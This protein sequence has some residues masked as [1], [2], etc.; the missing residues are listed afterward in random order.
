MKS[1][2]CLLLTI[3][4]MLINHS[5]Q[6]NEKH[7]S[8][9]EDIQMK[10]LQ[11]LPSD[12]DSIMAE[13]GDDEAMKDLIT[14]LGAVS[15]FSYPAPAGPAIGIVL[16]LFVEMLLSYRYKSEPEAPIDTKKFAKS[17][18]NL[19]TFINKESDRVIEK[20]EETIYDEMLVN[21]FRNSL[22]SL[23]SC[24]KN[25]CYN[26]F[27]KRNCSSDD[28]KYTNESLINPTSPYR[29]KL[30]ELVPNFIQS[31][32]TPLDHI[33]SPMR[34]FD[35]IIWKHKSKVFIHLKFY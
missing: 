9:K 17:I 3:M 7:R 33:E 21:K 32:E 25:S 5:L 11:P 20:L 34:I 23:N 19:Q 18:R 10:L 22:N 28:K 8:T 15:M 24:H 26:C 29:I 6:I 1:P 12:I 31:Q 16:T 35:Y 27:V 30:S 13:Y 2:S 14:R 4:F